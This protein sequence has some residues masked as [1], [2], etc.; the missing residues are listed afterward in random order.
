MLVDWAGHWLD[1]FVRPVRA[2]NTVQ[3]YVYALRQLEPLYATPLA[4][5]R[6]SQLQEIVGILS[7]R[8]S[9]PNVQALVGVWRR[10][11]DAAVD[12]EL[13]VRN[14]SRRLVLPPSQQRQARRTLTASEIVALMAGSVGHRFEGAFALLLGCGLRIGEAMGLAWVD[15]DLAGR[16]AWIHRQWTS[17]QWRDTPKG[18][19]AHWVHLPEAVAAALIRHRN[20][21]PEGALLVMQS[22]RPDRPWR[23]QTV[24]RALS[25]L[26]ADLGL[27]PITAHSSRHGLTSF[28]FNA[29]VPATEISDRLGHS[30]PAIL[31][32]HYAHADQDSRDQAD[33]LIDTL[34]SG[35]GPNDPIGPTEEVSGA[36]CI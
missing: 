24:G 31:L 34:L 23:S 3:A 9:A 2:P 35:I 4:D 12:D 5:L 13:I 7:Q 22:E 8:V 15:V 27:P 18:R 32:R 6:P 29:G 20:S 36:D 14:P 17:N 1:T 30:G 33:A 26:A 21:Q 10:C 11:L 25:A 16:R 28:L 19:R